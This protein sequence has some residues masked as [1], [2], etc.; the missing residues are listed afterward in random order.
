MWR[1]KTFP[2]T[3]WKLEFICIWPHISLLVAI[4]LDRFVK[5][6]ILQLLAMIAEKERAESKR[7]QAQGIKIAKEK[8]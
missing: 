7:R 3:F 2:H 4:P 8:G 1:I 5:D 6:L